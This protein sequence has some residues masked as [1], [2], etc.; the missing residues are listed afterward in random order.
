MDC[1]YNVENLLLCQVSFSKINGNSSGFLQAYLTTVT[2][3]NTPDILPKHKVLP[4]MEKNLLFF[5]AKS[6]FLK[7][8][9]LVPLSMIYLD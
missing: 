3:L 4:D 6:A 8:F 9:N 7:L 2:L 5:S 1:A